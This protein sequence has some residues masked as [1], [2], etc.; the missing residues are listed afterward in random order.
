MVNGHH[1]EWSYVSSGVPQGSIL[2]PFLFVL[3]VNDLSSV[4]RSK[5]KMF[6]DDGTLYTTVS[7]TE[8]CNKLQ[9]D[10]D[11]VSSWCA[12]WQMNLNPL[13]CELLC[14]S[15][16]LLPP[17]FDYVLN[18]FPL[19]WCTSVRYLGVH[20]NSKLSWND[21]CSIITAKATRVLNFLR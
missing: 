9:S 6:A 4:V 19:K 5:I 2:G 14:I 17:K 15:N 8:N 11:L 13:K 7:T 3:Y 18:G 1:S 20:I 10:L 12:H 21:H 16:K